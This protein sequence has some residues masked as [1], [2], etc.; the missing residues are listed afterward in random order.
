MANFICLVD[1]DEGRRARFIDAVGPVLRG[2]R[3]GLDVGSRSHGLFYACWASNAHA[4]ISQ[5]EDADGAAIIWGEAISG[6][7]HVTISAAELKQRF[8]DI[9]DQGLPPVLDGYHAAAVY[10]TSRATTT[11]HSGKPL[12]K[13][14]Q[15]KGS[16]ESDECTLVV[17]ADLLG[18][19]PVYYYAGEDFI[20]VSSSPELFRSHP[21]FVPEFNPAGLVGILLTMHPVN[22]Q[23]L[24]RGVHRLSAGHVLRWRPGKAPKEIRQYRIPVSDQYFSLPF[25]VQAE[26][27]D[28]AINEAV[29]RHV[30]SDKTCS[31]LLSGGRDSRMLAGYLKQQG[32]S[33]TAVTL[34]QQQD[35]DMTFGKSV[36]RTLGLDHVPIAIPTS[37]YPAHAAF[38]ATWL[39]CTS[40]TDA[41]FLWG[42]PEQLNQVPPYLVTGY[43]LD[44]VAGGKH[45]ERACDPRAKTLSFDTFFA[46]TNCNAIPPDMLRRLL[47]KEV[48]GDLVDETLLTIRSLYNSYDGLESQRAWS[49]DLYH[50][51]RFGLGTMGWQYSFGAWPIQ[52]ATDRRLLEVAAGIPA[53]A[54]AERRLQDSILCKRFPALAALPLDRGSSNTAPLNPRWQFRVKQAFKNRFSLPQALRG[55][56]DGE[57]RY[58]YRQ[59]EI[60]GEGWVAIRRQLH[61]HR[62]RLLEL[63]HPDALAELFPGPD[64]SLPLSHYET[65]RKGARLRLLLGFLQWYHQN[66]ETLGCSHDEVKPLSGLAACN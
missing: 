33:P 28:H 31:L 13:P 15:K 57:R 62:D 14:S 19:F 11:G 47:R 42:V 25:S 32:H 26:I 3:A 40:T 51:Q 24:W 22:G 20:L 34:G 10:M 48:F 6:T 7:D 63:F 17:S 35:F 44:A 52:P 2:F 30:P 66:G 9:S 45:I 23:T 1:G 37:G 27:L 8:A 65:E 53:A 60:N 5:A 4:P 43:M 18:T 61:P 59:L 46:N 41:I 39:H 49:F 56:A 36:A 54:L 12:F 29:A 16:R 58:W 38:H 21:G 64:V 50:H 55:Q